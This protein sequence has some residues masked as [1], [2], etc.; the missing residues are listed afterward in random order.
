M[1]L[2]VYKA[3]KKLFPGVPACFKRSRFWGHLVGDDVKQLINTGERLGVKQIVIG[4]R[5]RPGQHI[6]LCGTPL[7]KA[8]REGKKGKGDIKIIGKL[9]I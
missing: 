5:G 1:E 6:D 7:D 3:Q 8:I 4:R 2:Q 9:P